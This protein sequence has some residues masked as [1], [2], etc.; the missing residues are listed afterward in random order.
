MIITSTGVGKRHLNLL[1]NSDAVLSEKWIIPAGAQ[2]S[3][4]GSTVEL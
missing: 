2:V 3:V 1:K 4:V